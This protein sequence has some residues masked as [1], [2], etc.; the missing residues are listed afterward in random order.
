MNERIKELGE[1]VVVTAPIMDLIGNIT[2]ESFEKAAAES[3]LTTEQVEFLR[4]HF[5]V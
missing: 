3:H 1:Q 2:K 4:K 5:G